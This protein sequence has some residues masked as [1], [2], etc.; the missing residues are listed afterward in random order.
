MM[1]SMMKTVGI[2]MRN[3]FGISSLK[4][5][6]DFCDTNIYVIYAQNGMMKTS[7]ARSMKLLAEGKR[8]EIK[9]RV[10]DRSG[11]IVIQFNDKILDE[12]RH[13]EIYVVDGDEL[14]E[15][16]KSVAELLMDDKVCG[17]DCRKSISEF[18]DV[19]SHLIAELKRVSHDSNCLDDFR[20]A[21]SDL[22]KNQYELLFDE[23]RLAK[24]SVVKFA[25][26][27]EEIADKAGRIAAFSNKYRESIREYIR[28]WQRIIK[29]SPLFG[30]NGEWVFDSVRAQ[31]LIK[32]LSDEAFFRIGHSLKL[33]GEDVK[34][35]D[36][37]KK[38][39]RL[40]LRELRRLSSEKE[41][42]ALR[43]SI[44]KKMNSNEDLRKF[45]QLLEKHPW[46]LDRLADFDEFKKDVWRN[47]LGQ[48]LELCTEYC[49]AFKKHQSVIQTVAECSGVLFK[50][51]QNLIEEY[52]ARFDMPFE[53]GIDNAVDVAADGRKSAKLVYSKD[54]P[55][56]AD[57]LQRLLSR[58]EARAM[59]LMQVII[60]VQAR[61]A[62][63]KETLLILDDVVDSFDYKNK[64]AMVEYLNDILGSNMFKIIVLTHNYD[65]FR[66]VSLRLNGID[67]R[68]RLIALRSRNGISIKQYKMHRNILLE[69]MIGSVNRDDTFKRAR[70]IA[71]I[72]LARNL[73]E[74]THGLKSQEYLLLTHCLHGQSSF[75]NGLSIG[76]VMDVIQRVLPGRINKSLV[77]FVNGERA[78]PY[79]DFV[80]KTAKCVCSSNNIDSLEHKTTLAI[81]IRLLVEE[82]IFANV[83]EIANEPN[84]DKMQMGE[85]VRFYKR[86]SR[87]GS[88]I[89]PECDRIIAILDRATIVTPEYIHVNSFMYES[90][91]D[92][93]IQT[94]IELYRDV[95]SWEI[96]NKESK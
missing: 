28:A 21:F 77:D 20:L 26:S 59:R 30:Q 37:A 80:F 22:K 3:C 69:W 84:A 54:R 51:W 93:G 42:R 66:L 89:N 61:I 31:A 52:K 15:A 57:E 72:P 85:M 70:F 82:Y 27:Y 11:H 81:A 73:V 16:G 94:L 60:E 45:K 49:K 46:I 78:I 4:Y 56:A 76:N 9:D 43:E 5:K 40:Y 58:G 29:N 87:S 71:L 90:L 50:R 1:N 88:L 74:Y 25:F 38:L 23:C 32:T 35:I 64:Y 55:F 10:T 18:N 63:G 8:N 13:S 96:P 67:G 91:I 24:Q 44:E 2:D 79:Q 47:Y 36:S 62:K 95:S 68:N 53:V 6:F 14:F 86:R 83:P 41:L 48:M 39:E 65:F 33:K 75:R 12:R 7:F 34:Y 19:Y 92:T 17:K